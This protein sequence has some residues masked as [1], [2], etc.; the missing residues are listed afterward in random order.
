MRKHFSWEKGL[1]DPTFELALL[2]LGLLPPSTARL[3]ELPPSQ[4][5]GLQ[6]VNRWQ[7]LQDQT[8][9]WRLREGAQRL[10]RGK[11]SARLLAKAGEVLISRTRGSKAGLRLEINLPGN[12]D[13]IALS[14]ALRRAGASSVYIRIKDEGDMTWSW[15]L[16]LAADAGSNLFAALNLHDSL[17]PLYRQ[18][19]LARPPARM[20]IAFF[21]ASLYEVYRHLLNS[22]YRPGADTIVVFGGIGETGHLTS[23]LVEKLRVLSGAQAVVVFETKD[24]RQDRNIVAGLITELSHDF[25]LDAAIGR[26]DH[27]FSLSVLTCATRTLV[28]A[29]SLR[30]QA[31]I[32]ARQLQKT[33]GSISV[34]RSTINRIGRVGK[35]GERLRSYSSGGVFRGGQATHVQINARDLGGE[36]ERM[37]PHSSLGMDEL[38]SP[39]MMT[40]SAESGDATTIAELVKDIDISRSA[41]I[42]R[43]EQRFLQACLRTP[44]GRT[45]D[46]HAPLHTNSSYVACVFIGTRRQSWLGLGK[47]LPE[48]PPRPDGSPLTLQIMFWEPTA[49]KKPRIVPLK[50]FPRGDTGVATF[51]FT[52]AGEPGIFSARIAVYHRGRVLQTGLLKGAV[53]QGPCDFT[54]TPD[55]APHPRFAGME[56]RAEVGASIIF[57]D[58]PSG[59][60]QAFIHGDGEISVVDVTGT[61][62]QSADDSA[63]AVHIEPSQAGALDRLTAVLGRS[64]GRISGNPGL[65]ANLETKGTRDLLL[66]L[67]QHGGYLLKILQTHSK[68]Q[69][70]FDRVDHI[71]IVQA[72]VDA[73]FPAEYLYSGQVPED[74]AKLCTCLKD[75]EHIPLDGHCA[76]YDADP[77]HTICPLKFWS[78]SKVIER[79]AHLPEHT[80]LESEFVLRSYPLSSRDR[81]LAPLTGAVLAAADKADKAV[82]NTVNNLRIKLSEILNKPVPVASDWDTW[83]K[84][85]EDT[86]PHLL[87]LLPHHGRSGGF[88]WL[89][90]GAGSQK[91]AILIKERHVRPAGTHEIRPVVLL[92]GCETASTKIDLENFV[93]AFQ[94]AGAAIIVSTTATILGR[95][96]GPVTGVI[97]EELK[98]IE[99]DENATFGQAMLAARR[100][101]LA[102]GT[103]MV[104]GLTSYGDA[105]WRIVSG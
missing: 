65:Y 69:H 71:Q 57:N 101:L 72:H 66:E 103:P 36:L 42:R 76:Q 105:D 92:I 13:P 34:R 12:F 91:K 30:K 4:E 49:A 38:S 10:V 28:H 56:D 96:A 5:L 17:Q 74:D 64:I 83:A 26:L 40:F 79:H 55:A 46:H 77:E 81:V 16:L 60:M 59:A 100:R 23:D 21:S 70:L 11:D 9:A 14:A 97:V 8:W 85:I 15:P 2:V 58:D 1:P 37:L 25:P 53:G 78:M 104:L 86:S 32:L 51:P 6:L 29:T 102:A 43:R 19:D 39:D 18:F 67:A 68:M 47:P 24:I 48:P 94:M 33:K 63:L 84:Y 44:S 62:P 22:G 90:I 27:L 73:F 54:F 88:D 20:N 61:I 89:E 3:Q 93:P 45:V 35:P 98:R 80:A 99:D 31:H 82:P 50:I 75:I 95:Q 87:V 41:D 52:T 7:Q